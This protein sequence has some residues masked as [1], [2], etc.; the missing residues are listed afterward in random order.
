MLAGAGV[1]AVI[2]G[3]ATQKTFGNLV[4]GIFIAIFEPFRV[5]DKIIFNGNYGTVQDITLGHTIIQT[6]DN[7]NII[8]PNAKISDEVLENYTFQDA[9]LLKHIDLG[10]SYDSDIDLA[11]SLIM[12]EITTHPH[13]KETKDQTGWNDK[14]LAFVRVTSWKE[15]SITLRVYFWTLNPSDGYVMMCDLIES[16]KK[17]FDND[18]VEI[19]FPYRTIVYKNDLK[20]PLRYGEP[21]SSQKVKKKIKK[22]KRSVKKSHKKK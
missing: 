6:W 10:I 13:Y 8:V 20:K 19:P 4:S 2:I 7:R 9:K 17:R 11:R 16:I 3:F 15:S 5:G 12:D 21:K 18:G 14:E 1:F 22:K